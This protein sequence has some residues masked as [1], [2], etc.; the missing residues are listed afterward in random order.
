[1]EFDGFHDT[2]MKY[3]QHTGIYK[4]AAQDLTARFKSIRQGLKKWSRNL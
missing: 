3:W 2:V 4:N 1:M